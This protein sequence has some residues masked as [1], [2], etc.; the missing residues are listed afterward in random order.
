MNPTT[1]TTALHQAEMVRLRAELQVQYARLQN[2]SDVVLEAKRIEHEAT[3]R[4]D[5][6]VRSITWC[7]REIERE[8]RTA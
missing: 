7:E 5:E 2:A 8:G 4:I 6:I 3:A 1:S